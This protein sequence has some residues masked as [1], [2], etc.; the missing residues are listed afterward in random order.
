MIEKN[1]FKALVLGDIHENVNELQEIFKKKFSLNNPFDFIFCTGDFLNLENDKKDKIVTEEQIKK[2]EEQ[3]S[4]MVD[5]LKKYSNK[6]FYVPGNHDP[7][8]IYENSE[9]I[10]HPQEIKN[11]HGKVEKIA[12]KLFI[13]GIGG[14]V[15]AYD[16][17]G[18]LW[19]GFPYKDE[20]KLKSDL[21]NLEKLIEENSDGFDTQVIILSHTGPFGVGTTISWRNEKN[22]PIQGGSLVLHEW[23]E[24]V[25]NN[26]KFEVLCNLHGHV[27]HGRGTSL[28]HNITTV[29]PGAIYKKQAALLNFSIHETSKKWTINSFEFC[30]DFFR[31]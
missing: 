13:A 21:E 2:G 18:L 8:S 9:K 26:A 22:G 10:K 25:R 6:V 5:I 12:P 28:F 30:G 4:E 1:Q 19:N 16:K 24:S 31:F 17:S 23:L 7:I 3:I 29:N 15:D 27:H 20:Q 11:I 14:S